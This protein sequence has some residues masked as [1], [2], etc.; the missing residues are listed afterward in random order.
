MLQWYTWSCQPITRPCWMRR[1]PAQS[2]RQTRPSRPTHTILVICTTMA[3]LPCWNPPATASACWSH[4]SGH[5]N[6][7]HQL[8][9]CWAAFNLGN[10][11]IYLHFLIIYSLKTRTY[12][13]CVNTMTADG[14]VM[15]WARASTAMVLIL[16]ANALK[17][18]LFC[19]L[20]PSISFCC[21]FLPSPAV[22]ASP[23]RTPEPIYK[24]TR[25]GTTTPTT[26]NGVAS[27]PTPTPTSRFGCLSL[28]T[29]SSK[30]R[31][32]SLK[33]LLASI[34]GFSMKVSEAA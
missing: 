17:L 11:K 8:D 12:L 31:T 13:P 1:R 34:P 24:G 27:P 23:V 26:P 16:F 3:P 25:S 7:V 21:S 9:L 15:Q 33:E 2:S 28:S 18:W 20:F 30:P 19:I 4:G 32:K 14:L 22:P 10:M 6:E 5:T 29:M